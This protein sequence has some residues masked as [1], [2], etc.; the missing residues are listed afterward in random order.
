MSNS[1]DQIDRFNQ[2][3]DTYKKHG[4]QLKRVL[5][6]PETQSSQTSGRSLHGLNIQDSPIDALWF[7][8]A[9]NG[10]RQAWELRHVGDTP[11][12]L[13]E[14]FEADES[15][16][17]REGVRLEMEARLLENAGVESNRS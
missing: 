1:L 5:M 7:S 11:Y 8:R 10:G 9:S 2:T 13:F 4:W 17:D 14:L 16:E 15:E 12:A 6:C 3:I